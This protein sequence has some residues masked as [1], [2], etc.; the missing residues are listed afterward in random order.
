MSSSSVRS[1]FTGKAVWL[2]RI[3]WIAA[4]AVLAGLIALIVHVVPIYKHHNRAAQEV[5]EVLT[6]APLPPDTSVLERDWNISSYEGAGNLCEAGAF[7]VIQSET[8]REKVF[9]FYQG[10][11]PAMGARVDSNF[12]IAPLDHLPPLTAVPGD[13]DQIA[14]HLSPEERKITYIVWGIRPLGELGWDVR[15]W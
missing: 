10:L 7:I 15:G 12:H 8:P 3:F 6:S 2:F 1:G 5:L 14:G 9:A 13:I 4:I 11:F